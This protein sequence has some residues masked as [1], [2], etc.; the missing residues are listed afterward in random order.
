MNLSPKYGFNVIIGVGSG[1]CSVQ[2]HFSIESTENCVPP[3]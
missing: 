1:A 3:F 2:I